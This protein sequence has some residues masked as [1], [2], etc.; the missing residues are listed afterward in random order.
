M[1]PRTEL[2]LLPAGSCGEWE[3]ALSP[4]CWIYSRFLQPALG[5]HQAVWAFYLAFVVA[6]VCVLA[7]AAIGIFVLLVGA[8]RTS[9][10]RR[11]R[12]T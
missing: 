4:P 11:R 5:D 10:Q 7:A 1:P 9:A 6:L 8:E 3:R 2:A 12:C